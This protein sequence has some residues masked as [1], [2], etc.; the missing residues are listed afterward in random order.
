MSSIKSE[1]IL[2]A[3]AVFR[4]GHK[5]FIVMPLMN[6]GSLNSII[7]FKY[8]NGIK[9]ES[10]IATVMRACLEAIK[11]LNA[12]DLFH[13]DI[14]AANILLNT[15]GSIKLGDFGVSAIFK[16]FERKTSFVGSAYWMAPEIIKHQSYDI[17]VDIWSIG[18]TAIEMADG[19]PPFYGMNMDQVF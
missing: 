10:A 18:I 7:S 5:V 9:D 4:C 17:K 12:N 1:Y 6:A 14:K 2:H 8:P 19:K 11:A 16:S 13:R 15:D 3:H